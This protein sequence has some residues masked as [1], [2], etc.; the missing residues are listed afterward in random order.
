M[1]GSTELVIF[2][3]DGVLV[4]SERIAIKVHT[5]V[6]TRLGC[7]FT[8]DEVAE[9]FVGVSW[10]D[11]R[12]AAEQQLGRSLGADWRSPYEHLYR[13]ASEAELEPVDGI[14]EA[15]AALTIP[16]CVASNGTHVEIRHSL[17]LT[18]LY[19]RFHGRIFSADDVA[20]GKPAPD[21][22]LHAARTLDVDPARC[23][24]V[25]DSTYGVRAARAA[26]MRVLGYCGGLTPADRLAGPGTQL[27]HEMRD[28]PTLLTRGW[29]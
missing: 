22:F 18:G 28:L 14:D 7:S 26:G 23:V 6:L 10:D 17:R 25:E 12:L 20:R 8:L 1:A 5:E 24:V 11:L 27:F 9:K 21:L 2:D 13:D 29:A 4:D 19:E 3:C 15:V 16:A